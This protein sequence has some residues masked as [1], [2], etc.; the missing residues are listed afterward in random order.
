MSMALD[1]YFYDNSNKAL[2]H[3]T[4]EENLHKGIFSES[5]MWNSYI[6]LRKLRDYYGITFYTK[7]E[8]LELANDLEEYLI[9]IESKY[10]ERIIELIIYLRDEK[11]MKA[12][13]AGD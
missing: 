7:R 5:K 2:I 1:V 11:F 3:K 6:Q 10:H 12:R 4:F 8:M 13:F 9:R